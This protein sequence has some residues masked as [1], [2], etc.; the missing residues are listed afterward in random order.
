MGY[1]SD[2]TIV[3]EENAFKA[4][5]ESIKKYNLESSDKYYSFKPHLVNIIDEKIYVI[6]WYYVKWYDDFKDVRSVEDVLNDLK[7][8]HVEEDGYGFKKII[9]GE[10]N[11]ITEDSNNY[12]LDNYLQVIC[13][14]VLNYTEIKEIEF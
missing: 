11:N 4:I 1:R 6:K 7:E 9:I 10:D 3:L 14:T 5:K 2:V 8:N 13:D 12:N